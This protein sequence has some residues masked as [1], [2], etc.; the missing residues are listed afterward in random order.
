MKRVKPESEP[1]SQPRKFLNADM[2]WTSFYGKEQKRKGRFM[3][4][5][6]ATVPILNK[7]YVW[8]H[9]IPT[10]IRAK[11]QHVRDVA[12]R[13]IE[14]A[15]DR[16]S[17]PLVMRLGH[18][19]EELAW[20]V[21]PI[22]DGVDGVIPIGWL[23][24]HNPDIDWEKGTLKWR[25]TYCHEHC[26]PINLKKQVKK[27]LELLQ[28]AK[29]WDFPDEETRNLATVWHDEEGGDVANL[30]PDL[31]KDW[32]DVFSEEQ[33]Q[34]LPEH[35]S[36]DHEIRLIE[37][38]KPPFGPIYAL[39]EKELEELRKHLQKEMAA[40]KIRRS[41]SPAA[42]PILFVPKADGSLRMCVDYRSLNN[43]TEKDASPL[44]LMAE[45]RERLARA[46]IFTKIDLKNGFN[47]IR[48]ATGDE[49]KTAFRTRYGLYE[50]LVMPI[51]LCN[52]PASFQRMME[53]V[54]TGLTDE[55]VVVYIDDILIYSET[56]EEHV[57]LTKEVLNRLRKHGLCANIK[58]S[59]FHVS[60]V[61]YLG[62]MISEK[63]ISMSEKKV[64]KI[65]DWTAPKTVKNV[66][67]FLGFANFYRRFIDGYSETCLPLT[68]LTK[69]DK[70][71]EW[72]EEHQKAFEELKEK[73]VTQ[74]I[75]AHFVSSKPT[76]V[77]TDASDFAL[78]A[79]LSQQ[80]PTNLWH[81]VAFHARKFKSAE[82]NYDI[83]DKEMLAIVVAFKEW[84]HMLKSVKG[85]FTVFTDHKNLEY[86]ST[87][88]VLTRRQARWSEH[89]A[90]YDFVII[91]RPGSKNGKAD[92]LSRRWDYAPEGGGESPQMSFFKPGQLIL[93]SVQLAAIPQMSLSHSLET[94]IREAAARDPEHT[95]TA[96]ATTEGNPS[97][98][99]EGFTIANGILYF[100]NRWVVPSDTELKLGILL[101][102][103]DAKVA[104]HFGQYKTLEKVRSNFFWAKM[105]DEV[106]DYVR[107][108]DTCQR[109]KASRHAKYGLL[110]PT[111]IPHRPWQDISMDFITG[112]PESQG[113]DKIWV[114]VDLLTKMSHFIP[115]K[116]GAV[117][118]GVELATVFARDIWRLHGLPSSII[119]DRDTNFTSKFW[120]H[121]T[122]L[123]GIKLR[124][125]T[126]FHLQ[127]DGQTERA[128]Q[129]LEEY[130]RHYVNY[131]QDDW[132]NLLPMA[133]HAY[134]V[135]PSETT[136]VSPFF[137]NYGFNPETQWVKATAKEDGN[138]A[139][140]LLVS[141]F[142]GVWEQL[143]ENI[144]AA[145]Q[146]MSKW[147]N[148]KHKDQPEIKAGDMVMID[149]KHLRS[150]RPSKKLD[151]R[152]MGPFEVIQAIGKRAFK[153]KLPKKMARHHTFPISILEPYRTSTLP[154]RHQSPPPPEI[155]EGEDEYEVEAI[156]DSRKF[157]GKVQYYV[158]WKGYPPEE[159]TWE[160][161]ESLEGCAETLREF[162]RR[163]PRKPEDP[164]ARTD[165]M[166]LD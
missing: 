7:D 42:S 132:V 136:R 1:V 44:P 143:Q 86:F 17:L 5:C 24:Q 98:I 61:E 54:L 144:H 72:R 57:R 70:I 52:A 114:I 66:Q 126:A 120:G 106:R 82:R 11:P 92:V 115:L 140:E 77:E 12:G 23:T 133:E 85:T 49:W 153:L 48:I 80:Q 3:L 20:E 112:L 127:T 37:G 101:E 154:G 94:A 159:M 152:K 102:C 27:V 104:G 8:K 45:L 31:Y 157:R 109:D 83:H 166:D 30:L 35:S 160:P 58:K 56:E 151:H 88:K 163:Y 29:V 148:T 40:G 62:Y 93:S 59:F 10:V 47:L 155:V 122:D 87:T 142:K 125:S 118:P 41:Q 51:G 6:G 60:E 46:K 65:R 81:P 26:L 53:T 141:R 123:L 116:S 146:R 147:Y 135:A 14:G 161:W 64:A 73:F 158:K 156:A 131:Q 137:A 68:E 113:F 32:A 165:A 22:E 74:P 128:N 121:L 105:E 110:H 84:E 96:Q 76:M 117:E 89:L 124:M 150:A 134:N 103:H 63:G 25:S 28:E 38:A 97:L 36:F 78:G 16:Y 19:Q 75:L 15:G 43:V 91:Y 100:K 4:D 79:I 21:G 164:R 95:K 138:P 107:S 139:A 119:S 13:L 162:H 55:G 18:H 129:T 149:A 2:Y 130:L 90:E 145:Q 69:G 111:E 99:N 108:C 33:I 71:F 67:E 50:Y 34:K 9:K 39:S